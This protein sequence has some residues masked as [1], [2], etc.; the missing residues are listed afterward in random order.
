MDSTGLSRREFVRSTGL[1]AAAV[2]FGGA[3]GIDSDPARATSANSSALLD[4][5]RYDGI[6]LAGLVKAREVSPGELLE[7]LW[8]GTGT[9]RTGCGV[10]EY[11]G[12][13][14]SRRNGRCVLLEWM[15]SR[16]L[17]R[18]RLPTEL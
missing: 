9:V 11:T 16:R 14:I 13:G 10:T 4:Y 2:G 3:I 1:A 7:A 12:L 17:V 8:P 5:E 18:S 6:G 15:R